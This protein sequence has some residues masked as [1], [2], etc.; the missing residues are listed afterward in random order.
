[1]S[2]KTKLLLAA[3]L[4]ISIITAYGLWSERHQNRFGSIIT[5]VLLQSVSSMNSA[6][7]LQN[8]FALYDDIMLR[9]ML[10]NDKYLIEDTKRIRK[11]AELKIREL[12]KSSRSPTVKKL[13]SDIEKESAMYFTDVERMIKIYN[14]TKFPEG[15]A[16]EVVAIWSKQFSKHNKTLALISAS[17]RQRLTRIY[18]LCEKLLDI[19]KIQVENA[20]SSMENLIDE[21]QQITQWATIATFAAVSLVTILLALSILK[22]LN[23]LLNGV[24]RIMSGDLNFEMPI[25][26]GDEVGKLTQAFNSMTTNL[27]EKQE[28][29]VQETI[30][31]ELT[32]IYNFRY[33]QELIKKELERARRYK[34][35]LSV[36][37]VDIDH[38]KHYNDTQGHEMG[39]VILKMIA[40]TLKETLRTEDTLSRYG[41]EEFGVLLPDTSTEQGFVVAERL[42]FNIES[43]PF[44][45]EEKQPLGKL[46]VSIGGATFPDNA[47][48]T[49]ALIE[50][51]DQALYK[52]KSDGRNKLTFFKT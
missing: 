31:D 2:I 20:K 8:A 12:S 25:T 52:S 14:E 39:N 9:F 15:G 7:E 21:G 23:A 22:P 30:T 26:S 24:G 45:G 46:T 19:N 6:T 17:G 41:G 38:Y 5:D 1:M 48:T 35:P 32:G 13:L 16:I 44:P 51:A 47:E 18:S 42:R 34:R 36:L 37:I 49:Q 29:L 28:Q 40:Q 43:A 27:R 4:A 11:T 3:A 33:F 10:T 50:Y